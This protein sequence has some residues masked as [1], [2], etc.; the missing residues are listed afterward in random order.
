MKL[1]EGENN[2]QKDCNANPVYLKLNE[3]GLNDEDLLYY[4]YPFYQGEIA[5]ESVIAQML[6]ISIEHGIFLIDYVK[7]KET[8]E[9]VKERVDSLF[10]SIRQ[11]LSILPQ[12]RL[13]KKDLKYEINTVIINSE[14][15]TDNDYIIVPV[16]DIVNELKNKYDKIEQ[17]DFPLI[18]SCIDGTLRLQK[19][20]ER[21]ISPKLDKKGDVLNEIQKYISNLDIDQKQVACT[22]ADGPQRIRGLAGSGKTIVLTQKAANYML[23]HPDEKILYTYYTK[24]LYETI[25]EHIKKAYQFFSNNKEPNWDNINICHGWGSSSTPGVYSMACEDNEYK[26]LTLSEAR[27]LNRKEPLSGACKD[28][29]DNV[30]IKPKYDLILIDEGQDFSPPFYQLCYKLS[31]NRKI[32]WAYDDFQNIFDINIQDEKETFGKDENGKYVVDFSVNSSILQDV[33]LKKCY[34]TPRYSLT[35]AFALGLG[36][37]NSRVLQ[38]IF[39]NKHWESL[40]FK[41][42]TGNSNSKDQMVISRPLE[43]SPSYSNSKFDLTTIKY[44]M[45]KNLP[46]ECSYIAKCI[47]NDITEENLNPTDICVICL[48]RKAISSYF[49][50][51]S[52]SLSKDGI[53]TFNLLEAPYDNLTFFRNDY[54]TLSSVNKAKGNECGAVY[55]CGTDYVFSSPDNVVL[56]DTLFTAMTRTKGWLT[57]TGTDDFQKGIEELTTLKNNDFKFKFIQPAECETKYIKDVSKKQ[58]SAIDTVIKQIKILKDFGLSD[59]T[60]LKL[61]KDKTDE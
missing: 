13:S 11:K 52:K 44:K 45:F 21:K 24:S 40:G 56:R 5:A 57:L 30:Q 51:I 18:Q 49:D 31:R 9:Q 29:I 10:I 42:E 50:S 54:V 3:M 38:S 33:V 8:L 26:R 22:D 60:I 16:N 27:E 34:R 39:S 46:E 37:Y 6:L 59:D 61:I 4:K 17:E 32:V 53:K 25:K 41:V 14:K 7:T 36:I 28:I 55:I 23:R 12:L 2:I 1:I 20:A 58:T 35:A 47:Y 43:N 15:I 48:D 19:K